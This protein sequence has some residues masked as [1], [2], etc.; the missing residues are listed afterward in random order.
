MRP[1]GTSQVSTGNANPVLIEFASS[2]LLKWRFGDDGSLAATIDN[3]ALAQDDGGRGRGR[4]GDLYEFRSD[5]QGRSG[6]CGGYSRGHVDTPDELALRE[7]RLRG[8]PTRA[9]GSV[10]RASLPGAQAAL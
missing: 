2:E 6:S 5:G 1:S 3:A 10:T 9:P 8:S 4:R 7:E